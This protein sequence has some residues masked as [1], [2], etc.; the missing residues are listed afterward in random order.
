M[1][2]GRCHQY[3]TRET[4]QCDQYQSIIKS[5]KNKLHFKKQVKYERLLQKMSMSLTHE[6]KEKLQKLEKEIKLKREY[7]IK[8]LP[9]KEAS[10]KATGIPIDIIDMDVIK[11]GTILGLIKKKSVLEG[12]EP[13]TTNSLLDLFIGSDDDTKI[14]YSN[15][16]PHYRNT[17][18]KVS[19]LEKIQYHQQFVQQQCTYFSEISMNTIKTQ[20]NLIKKYIS[21][22]LEE[23]T[24]SNFVTIVTDNMDVIFDEL[25]ESDDSEL[26]TILST[27]R[28]SLLGPLNVCEYKKIIAD[29]IVILRK[30]NKSH[31]NIL[32]HLSLIEARLILYPG[33]LNTQTGP[34]GPLCD[35]DFTKLMNELQFR[36]YT[37]NPKLEP[38]D[39][40]DI[41]RHCCT[42][43]LLNLPLEVVVKISLLG[44]YMNNSIGY[45]NNLLN[46]TP[47]TGTPSS[48]HV[49]GSGP[50][51]ATA[52]DPW[53]FYVLS[54][55]NSDGSRLWVLD[56]KIK[57]FSMIFIKFVTQYLIKIHRTFYKDCFGTNDFIPNFYNQ[58]ETTHFDVFLNIIR[59]VV[60]ISNHS[61]F[62]EFLK[63]V[64]IQK[65][66]IIPTEFDFFNHLTYYDEKD[67]NLEFHENCKINIESLFDTPI[68]EK[69]IKIFEQINN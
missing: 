52:V 69:I 6:Q 39:V 14:D 26:W 19:E 4:L 2:L 61:L 23:L 16:P 62:I 9:R 44:P 33:G 41:L 34:G 63:D 7:E 18:Q 31:K 35:S 49:A 28:N 47:L 1:N 53:S 13:N 66:C 54:G 21:I 8:S 5:I 51:G 30:H 24:I 57:T 32:N 22:N 15:I 11:I 46:N 59:N 45:L 42:P 37:K 43:S 12:K 10:S 64:I 25:I 50:Q 36:T 48:R 65:S 56:Y 67:S 38:F 60:F 29:Q 3:S 27:L 55:I 40:E 68:D 20:L 17:Q 58:T